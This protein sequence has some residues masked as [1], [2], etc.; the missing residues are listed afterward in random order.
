MVEGKKIIVVIPAYNAAKTLA[1]TYQDI[2]R[3]IVDE[4]ILVDD[5]SD[6]DTIEIARSL[7]IAH[8][9]GHNRNLGYGA[10]QKTCYTKALELEADVVIMLHADY[11]Y[12]PKKIEKLVHEIVYEKHDVVLA[13]RMK[14]NTAL[15]LG[16]PFYKYVANIILTKIQNLA[17]SQDISEYHTGYRAFT[18]KALEKSSFTNYSDDFIFDNQI[19]MSLMYKKLKFGEISCPAKYFKEASS[20]GLLKSTKYGLLVLF[21]T[22]RYLLA[23]MR[24]YVH[25]YYKD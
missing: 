12:D 11:Q 9:I 15:S 6:D 7:G 19:I 3:D 8:I 13:S 5:H 14:E 23:K 10:N 22:S 21:E 20:I 1:S 25:P 2:P 16:M 17:T 4:I 24:I 18:K